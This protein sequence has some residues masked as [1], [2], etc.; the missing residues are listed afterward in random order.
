M[1]SRT[2]TTKL[3]HVIF[4]SLVL[5][6]LI[7]PLVEIGLEE[8]DLGSILQQTRPVFLLELLL[9]QLHLDVAGRVVNVARLH[10][11]LGV[12]R[13]FDMVCALEGIRVTVEGQGSGLEVQ[14][15]VLFGYIWDGDG[16]VDEVL[17]GIGARR[18]LGP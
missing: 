4:G 9:A 2:H 3:R 18:A 5:L 16:Q 10:I 17:R 12:K 7:N 8:L 11:N 14:L 1:R 6:I 15:Q 13:E